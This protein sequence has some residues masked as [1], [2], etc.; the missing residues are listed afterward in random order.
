[1]KSFLGFLRE[2]NDE[3]LA[4]FEEIARMQRNHPENKM[5]KAQRQLQ[6]QSSK[7]YEE[8]GEEWRSTNTLVHAF[9]HVGDL[10]HRMT[11]LSRYGEY[12]TTTVS[13]KVN[14]CLRSLQNKVDRARIEQIPHVP[15]MK[16]YADE[17]SKIPVYNDAQYHAR[18]A[19]VN[20]GRGLYHKAEHHLS[21]L[22]DM[23]DNGT[24]EQRA[25]EFNQPYQRDLK[26]SKL[27]DP[28]ES[29]WHDGD[30]AMHIGEFAP[31]LKHQDYTIKFPHRFDY[32]TGRS[33]YSFDIHHDGKRIGG[34]SYSHYAKHKGGYVTQIEIDDSKHRRKGI[35]TAVY[36]HIEKT[37]GVK[38]SPSPRMEPDGEA[39][40]KNRNSKPR[41]NL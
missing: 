17:H 40:W 25:A 27:P 28:Y 15:A 16:E 22:K 18:E 20:L 7:R 14:S 36:N 21:R 6:A 23:L 9:E 34:G 11:E 1:M 12:M 35:A 10:T 26:E 24:Y 31:A 3:R 39:F 2:S 8:T 41:E 29:A 5:L 33:N 38:L 37:F 30:P 19:A 32:Q 13:Q 4:K